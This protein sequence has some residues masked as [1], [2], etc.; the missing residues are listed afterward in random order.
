[1]TTEAVVN[2]TAMVNCCDL[3]PVVGVMAVIAFQRCL[4]MTPAFTL[5]DNIVMAAR[6]NANHFIVVDSTV[7]NRRPWSWAGL[8]TGVADI[9]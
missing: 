8:V 2:E 7:C 1:M 4:D 3:R 6:A 5:R 9:R